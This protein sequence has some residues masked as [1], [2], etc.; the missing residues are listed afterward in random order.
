[1]RM[2]LGMKNISN[3]DYT[4]YMTF[5]SLE[6]SDE[7]K[8]WAYRKIFWKEQAFLNESTMQI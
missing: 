4:H 7:P 2:A 5:A 8:K 6:M 1:M 3:W